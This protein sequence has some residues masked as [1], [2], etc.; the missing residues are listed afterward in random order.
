MLFLATMSSL[1]Y[2]IVVLKMRAEAGA[3]ASRMGAPGQ[4]LVAW[5]QCTYLSPEVPSTSTCSSPLTP[6]RVLVF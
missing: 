1:R 4:R 5:Q 6:R 2:M 3:R